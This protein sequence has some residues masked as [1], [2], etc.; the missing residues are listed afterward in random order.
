M[1]ILIVGDSVAAGEYSNQASPR[2]K[3]HKKKHGIKQFTVE[4]RGLFITH[5]GLGQYLREEWHD[6]EII[7]MPGG[8]N[9]NSIRH[10]SIRDLT[11]YH[12]VFMFWTGPVRSLGYILNSE[13]K[14]DETAWRARTTESVTAVDWTQWHQQFTIDALVELGKLNH[15]IYLIGGQEQLPPV[16]WCKM[17][18]PKIVP[19]IHDMHTFCYETLTPPYY[20]DLVTSYTR[21]QRWFQSRFDE[22]MMDL[23]L[24]AL[25][26]W[27]KVRELH[28]E[29]Q[30]PH[31]DRADHRKLFEI[32][33]KKN[34][35]SL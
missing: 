32:I 14:V 35:L 23:N 10:L 20:R 22:S 5:G 17:D 11:K 9:H 29:T 27:D 21:E 3:E 34:A 24:A 13:G 16:G 25:D 4:N 19:L 8:S 30:D 12:K 28:P 18:A 26:Y 7:S 33:L 15:E 1:K 31:P 2:G 6:V